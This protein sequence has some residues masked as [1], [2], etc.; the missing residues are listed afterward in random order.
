MEVY[1][2]RL[3]KTIY[4]SY[5]I[6][7][8]I[9]GA[10]IIFDGEEVGTIQ[11][12]SFTF[13]I[14]QKTDLSDSH[15]ISIKENTGTLY[16][17]STDYI[18]STDYTEENRLQ[19]SNLK[20]NITDFSSYVTSTKT[21]YTQSYP[22]QVTVE[23]ITQEINLNTVQTPTTTTVPVTG[24]IDLTANHTTNVVEGFV[25]IT[26]DESNN[27]INLYYSQ[28]AGVQTSFI[29][30]SNIERARAVLS[31]LGA[32][33]EGLISQGY[34]EFLCWQD[35]WREG[36]MQ[37]TI[38]GDSSLLTPTQETYT[39]ENLTEDSV[40]FPGVGGTFNISI[41]EYLLNIRTNNLFL[42]IYFFNRTNS[43]YYS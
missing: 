14:P 41:L 33:R 43:Y 15:T 30:Y 16:Q 20:N 24:E 31:Y 10:T 2:T 1:K 29:I 19:I 18:F 8:D 9:E 22:T 11:N 38:I 28:D 6:R 17:K 40:T 7:S 3:I 12:G 39:F 37:A 21:E 42:S 27:K 13:R 5:L 23:N 4:N 32:S 35:E 36:Y 34:K 25:E 26:Q